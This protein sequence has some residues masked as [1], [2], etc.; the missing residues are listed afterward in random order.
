MY[1]ENMVNLVRRT[2]LLCAL[3]LCTF[4]LSAC[5]PSWPKCRCDDDCKASKEGNSAK[6]QFFC[7]NGAC[8]QC[9][10]A[11]DC[12]ER[13]KCEGYRCVE[14]TCSDIVCA[15]GK[16]CNPNTLSCEYICNSDGENPCDG[17][18]CKVCKNHQCVPKQPACQTS[19]DC[20]GKQICT[21]SG[22][23]AKCEAGCDAIKC[24]APNVCR[25]NV[26]SPP[27]CDLKLVYFDF[28][29][30]NIRSDAKDV[31]KSNAECA[32]KRSSQKI[33]IEGH[34][35]ERGTTEFNIQLGKRRARSTK[36]YLSGLGV[37]SSRICTVSKGKEDPVV[38]NASTDE[39]HQKNR[40]AVFR[41]V[42]SCP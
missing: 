42:D 17:D 35:D 28:N 30:A 23:D 27:A 14:K 12:S 24:K 5:P 19:N 25:N 10:T 1:A 36:K 6:K 22:C 15:G 3:V 39:G 29:R 32:N 4:V 18:R 11:K 7:V 41:F 21:G 38:P 40:R 8:A 2:S 37:D 20:P 31:L 26:C 16:R 13:Q 9:R 33:L 34:C